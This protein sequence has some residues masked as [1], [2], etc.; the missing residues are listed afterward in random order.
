VTIPFSQRTGQRRIRIATYNVHGWV[1]IDNRQVPLRA[2]RVIS[3]LEADIIALQEA[4]FSLEQGGHL[5]ESFL[6]RLTG[7]NVALGPTF[8]KEPF[9]FGNVILSRFP[10]TKIRHIDLSTHPYE[11]RAAIDAVITVEGREIRV[12]NAHFGLRGIERRFQS[13]MLVK[14]LSARPN[15]KVILMGD[16]NEWSPRCPTLKDLYALFSSTVHP[17]SFPSFFPVFAL[18][19]IL[20][21]PEESLEKIRAFMTPETVMASDHLPVTGIV[22]V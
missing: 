21:S 12:L 4:T 5:D 10:I 13:G 3:E 19:R 9:H 8:F 20:V 7:M 22:S 14:A 1:G 16:L 11:P 2:I 6:T 18:D 17:K 15:D